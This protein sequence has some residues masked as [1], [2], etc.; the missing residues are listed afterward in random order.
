MAD[1]LYR[2]VQG[3]IWRGDNAEEL[4][5]LANLEVRSVPSRRY[6]NRMEWRVVV[7]GKLVKVGDFVTD[8]G[9]VI[10][11]LLIAEGDPTSPRNRD[12]VWFV[13]HDVPAAAAP[14][15]DAYV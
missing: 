10:P 3:C 5:D 13:H 11:A 8:Q 4:P 14:A 12:K 1:V 6:A 15:L 9:D 2:M 7:G